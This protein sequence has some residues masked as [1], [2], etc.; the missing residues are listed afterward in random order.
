MILPDQK[1]ALL[2]IFMPN[3][4]SLKCHDTQ[5]Y[6]TFRKTDTATKRLARGRALCLS[7]IML[8]FS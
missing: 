4:N 1:H 8:A 7:L 5:I 2:F 3:T 6:R